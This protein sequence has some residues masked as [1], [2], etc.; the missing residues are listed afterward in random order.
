MSENSHNTQLLDPGVWRYICSCGQ[1]F[2][3]S[4]GA[5]EHSGE[6][7]KFVRRIDAPIEEIS[8]WQRLTDTEGPP[9]PAIAADILRAARPATRQPYAQSTRLWI[10]EILADLPL[11][12]SA[13]TIHKLVLQR[14]PH[15]FDHLK[16]SRK[17]VSTVIGQMHQA[18]RIHRIALGRYTLAA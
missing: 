12:G 5:E 4:I 11:G 8:H 13:P 14:D 18:N 6:E 9:P 16:N 17:T 10:E 2:A 15:A 1:A 3:T 7:G